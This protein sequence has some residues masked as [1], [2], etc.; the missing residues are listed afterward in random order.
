MLAVPVPHQHFL[1]IIT[2]IW[3]FLL[4]LAHCWVLPM[5][6]HLPAA[7]SSSNSSDAPLGFAFTA[8][9]TLLI[10]LMGRNEV[11]LF[12]CGKSISR[13]AAAWLRSSSY[14]QPRTDP[15]RLRCALPDGA[16]LL[17]RDVLVGGRRKGQRRK[18]QAV[19]YFSF[20]EGAVGSCRCVGLTLLWCVRYVPMCAA[21][22]NDLQMK[23][24]P[25]QAGSGAGPEEGGVCADAALQMQTIRPTDLDFICQVIGLEV[26]AC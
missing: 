1:A 13:T 9:S 20:S 18:G 8:S 12:L 10:V 14:G 26:C 2:G 5:L 6:P 17:Q 24:A 15:R 3:G 22:L 23:R 21:A 16:K 4:E 7:S 19:G 11:E 25:V